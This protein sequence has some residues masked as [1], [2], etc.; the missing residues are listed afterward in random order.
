MGKTAAYA[1]LVYP[2]TGFFQQRQGGE[3]SARVLYLVESLQLCFHLRIIIFHRIF[4]ENDRSFLFCRFLQENRFGFGRGFSDDNRNTGFDD[5]GLFSCY[6]RQCISQKL[7]VVE[8]DISNDAQIRMN[9]VC[10]VQTAAQSHFYDGYIHF[11]I[12][13]ITKCHG[14]SQFEERRMQRFKEIPFFFYKIH[15]IFFR[16]RLSVYADALAEIY[17]MRRSIKPHTISGFLQYGGQRM[18]T[19]A[20]AVSARHMNCAE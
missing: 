17:Q 4:C 5:A 16:Y 11:F 1:L 14:G 8:T 20:F 13:K 15:Y 2:V 3:D 18:R 7:D 9:D 6:F 12:G 10:T 19:R